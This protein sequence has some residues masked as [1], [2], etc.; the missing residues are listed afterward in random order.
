MVSCQKWARLTKCVN[1]A[2]EFC[3]RSRLLERLAEGST[4]A[5]QHVSVTGQSPLERDQAN[6]FGLAHASLEWTLSPFA[7]LA[8]TT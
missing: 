1:G 6:Y 5:D 8:V 4:L 3:K 2:R 7:L